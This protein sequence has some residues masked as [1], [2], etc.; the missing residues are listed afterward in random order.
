MLSRAQISV[1]RVGSALS[2]WSGV[3]AV[4]QPHVDRRGTLDSFAHEM[5]AARMAVALRED[6]PKALQ[7]ALMQ[8]Y[9]RGRRVPRS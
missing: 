6:P 1:N 3:L 8:A 4:V 2:P 5:V 7:L 9:Q